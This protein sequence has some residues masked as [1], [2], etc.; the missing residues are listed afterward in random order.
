[1]RFQSAAGP[2]ASG[3]GVTAATLPAQPGFDPAP[4][5]GQR[6]RVRPAAAGP[7]ASGNHRQQIPLPA[8][9]PTSFNPPPARRPAETS[10]L[11]PSTAEKMFQSAAGPKASGN[12]V[13][14]FV[15]LHDLAVSIR[16]RPEGQRKRNRP[17]P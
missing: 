4:P 14:V 13:A 12:D 5:E 11:L 16:R 6:K 3:N 10:S 7:K 8:Q 2:K 17:F 15:L 9:A 1:M